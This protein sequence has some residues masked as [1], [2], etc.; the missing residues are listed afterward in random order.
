MEDM[1]LGTNNSNTVEV[2]GNEIQHT[3]SA[4]SAPQTKPERL[5]KQQEV[6]DLLSRERKESVAKYKRQQEQAQNQNTVPDQN[7]SSNSDS[8]D[9]RRIAAEEAQRLMESS[10]VDAQRKAQME[11]AERMASDFF[12]KLQAGKDRYP[13]YSEV[14]GSVQDWG[15][16]ASA[17]G[18]ANMVDNTSDVMYDLLKN[19]LKLV[20]IQQLAAISPEHALRE[21]KKH[22]EALKANEK[23]SATQLP[24]E[25]LSQMRASNL[26]TDT[27]KMGVTDYRKKYGPNY[28]WR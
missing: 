25:P 9:I 28:K 6:A 21:I 4:N 17:V 11:Q 13:D 2:S 20:N 15:A 16:M 26:G 27:G 19:P 10:R 5:F 3:E 24:N 14:M 12:T 1:D 22:S 18:L 8:M 7:V 23:A